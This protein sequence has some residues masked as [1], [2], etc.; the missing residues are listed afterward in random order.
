MKQIA[1]MF[2]GQGSQKVGMAKQFYEQYNDV[3]ALFKEANVILNKDITELMLEGPE[4]TLTN[5]ENAQPALLLCSY[6]IYKVL[7]DHGIK[8]I[9][10]VVYYLGEY[11]D[12]DVGCA[13]S[14]HN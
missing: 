9:A 11:S 1:L 8:P 3:Q 10:A 12:H 2:P 7:A 6:I 13:L 5:T 4:S 14:L